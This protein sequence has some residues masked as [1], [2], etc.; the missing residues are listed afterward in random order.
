MLSAIASDERTLLCLIVVQS[1]LAVLHVSVCKG[2]QYLIEGQRQQAAERIASRSQ[3]GFE[4]KLQDRRSLLHVRSDL[5][6]EG[7]DP[8]GPSQRDD[9]VLADVVLMD[10]YRKQD[11]SRSSWAPPA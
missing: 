2:W 4:V 3:A 9:E 7:F 8:Q 11:P 10:P 6:N 5:A 1:S